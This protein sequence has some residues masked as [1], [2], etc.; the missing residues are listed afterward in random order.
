MTTNS[1]L[2]VSSGSFETIKQDLI[3]YLKGQDQFKDYD[4]KGSRLNVLTDLLA[5]NTM[6]MQHYSNAA[7]FEGFIRTAQKH[8]SVVQHA[9][10]MG[11]A[12][13]SLSA[14]THTIGIK[15]YNAANPV[16]I[17]L[18]TGT[19]F[20]ADVDGIENYGYIVWEPHILIG[21]KEDALD[22]ASPLVYQD[23]IDVV[24]GTLGRY[25]TTFSETQ[26][27]TIKDP[28]LDRNYVRV[29]VDSAEW[30]NWT[31]K[32]IVN[33]SGGSNVFYLRETVDGYTEVYFGEGELTD[34]TETAGAYDPQ[35]IG[36]LRPIE[37]Q[38]VRVQYVKTQG[39]V[40]NGSKNFTWADDIPNFQLD[41]K[42]I[43]DNPNDDEN[44]VGSIGG[45]YAEGTERIRELAPVFRES[46]RRCVTKLDYETF[47][48]Q[49]FGNIVQAVQAFGS[50][51]KPG[52]V[53]ISIKPKSGLTLPQVA[54]AD[55]EDYLK[56]F[57]IVTITPKV[58]DPDYLYIKHD[59]VVNYRT[60]SLSEG[61]DYL[62]AQ[63]TDAISDYYY[64]DVEIFNAS[65][66]VSK[67]LGYVDDAHDSIL[68]SRCDISL[69]RELVNFSQTPMSGYSF[70]NPIIERSVNSEAITYI[71]HDC[72]V[73]IKSTDRRTTETQEDIGT[74]LLGPFSEGTI[75]DPIDPETGEP[76]TEYTGDDFNR[77][78]IDGRSLYYRIGTVNY[79][80]GMLDY[81]FAN[82]GVNTSEWD[83]VG[84]LVV[85]ASP[86]RSNIYTDDG[87]LIVYENELRP[88]YTDIFL[89]GI[90]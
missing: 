54:R 61:A 80:T 83:V 4:F 17:T 13:S 47:V 41:D 86:T 8:S 70:L 73:F 79:A 51:E 64:N 75:T 63:I 85:S 76:T 19:R 66:H 52:Y 31:D 12:P 9:Q 38:R 53:F 82:L 39:P 25:E 37:G 87:S 43:D 90:S 46:Q 34:F 10:D 62:K 65:F 68:G 40:A 77:E 71:A 6:Y 48:S 88:Q 5:Y 60:G 36:G 44:F 23:Q 15:A 24:Q 2:P 3:K 42:N 89:E 35:Y 50:T 21:A 20:S 28:D 7:L 72:E 74:L 11:Y 58:V 57:N 16:E 26:S 81:E 49:K 18:G 14:S 1:N 33:V 29:F 45:G 55:I 84:N 69:I 59:L 30:T 27:I 67:M 22:P 78:V 56:E 32:S